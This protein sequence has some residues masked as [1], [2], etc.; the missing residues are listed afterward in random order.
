ML[1]NS[2]QLWRLQFYVDTGSR[3]R[4]KQLSLLRYLENDGEGT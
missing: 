1:E 3:E 2:T 4:L